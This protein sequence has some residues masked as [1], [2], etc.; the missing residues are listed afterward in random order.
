MT[1]EK[2]ALLPL[3]PESV[4]TTQ[5]E[6]RFGTYQG[7]LPEVDLPRLLGK[8]APART[9]RLLKRKRWHYTFTATQEVAALFAVVDLGY[10]SSAFAV[11][12]DLRERKVLC[13]VSFLGAP[14]PMVS[15]GDKPGAGLNASFRTLGGKLAIRRGEEDERYQVQVDVS[16]MRTGSLN[17]FQ[18]NGELLVAGGPPALTVIAPVQGDGLVN[19]TMKRNGLL[20][21]GSLEVGGKRFRLDGGVGGIDYTQG[22]LAR[23]TAWR[24]AFASGRLADGTPI[25]LNLVEG[26]NESATEANENALWLGDRLYPLARARFEYDTKNL[27]APWRLTTADGALDLRFQPFYVHRE[28]RNLRLV[29]SHFAQ[30]V[31]LFEG[32]VKVGSKTL[33]LS[34]LPGVTEDQDMLW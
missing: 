14:G 4:A 22:Y 6:P 9:T 17:T 18:W 29:I 3:A 27:M 13:D 28:E 33:Q 7:E 5:G 1:P 30:P 32:T 15:L 34:N 8:W 24:W 25:G 21:F 20:S 26:F 12:I 10:S 11:A 31:G 19:V 16:R 23:H 2:D